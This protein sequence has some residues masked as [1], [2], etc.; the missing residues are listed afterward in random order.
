VGGEFAV[1]G[2]DM[3]QRYVA[4]GDS[5]TE[6]V[7]DEAPDGKLRGW[8]DRFAAGLAE[9]DHELDYANLAVRGRRIRSILIEQVPEAL[10]LQPDLISVV[11][12]VNDVL[13][14]SWSLLAT[15]DALEGGVA[16]A[17][18]QGSDVLMITFGQPIRRSRLL[19]VVQ[20][21]MAEFRD[22]I[23][24]IGNAHDCYVLDLWHS[25]TFDDP[26]LWSDDRLHLNPAGHQRVAWAA[27]EAMGVAAP[28]WRQPL[29]ANNDPKLFARLAGDVQW[30][31]QHFAPWL[32]RRLLGRSSG[33]GVTA[34]RP[35]PVPV[36]G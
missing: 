27:L 13:R 3:W 5:F 9:N 4:V 10:A 6:G 33:D 36:T 25:D 19:G 12:G 34:K 2:N 11:G 28:N 23:L 14:P 18:R 30:T 15:A 22:E 8:A 26:R 21:R 20:E 17:R 24:R 7:G 35:E 16:R 31:A 32:G 29:P 1:E